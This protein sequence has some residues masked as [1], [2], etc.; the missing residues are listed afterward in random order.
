[1]LLLLEVLLLLS[2][3]PLVLVV[4]EKLITCSNRFAVSGSCMHVQQ[5][6]VQAAL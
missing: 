1:M 5:L 2:L 6:T 4:A 3:Q